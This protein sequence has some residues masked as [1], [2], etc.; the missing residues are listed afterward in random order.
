MSG[1]DAAVSSSPP[2]AVMV[3]SLDIHPLLDG[4]MPLPPTVLYPDVPETVWSAMSADLTADG[5]L[6]VPYGGFLV[7]DSERNRVLIDT[8]AGPNPSISPDGAL[9]QQYAELP[10]ALRSVG[11]APHQIDHVVLTHFH[12]DHVGWATLDG[13]PYFTRA[14]YH[15]HEL[16]WASLDPGHDARETLQPIS[17]QV[18]IWSGAQAQPLPWLTLHHVPGHSPGNTLVMIRDADDRNQLAVVG[19]LFHHPAGL[20]HPEW[21]CGF[22]ADAEVAA[23]QRTE[24]AARLRAAEIPVVSS[25]FPGLA[26][27]NAY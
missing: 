2:A 6:K 25:H 23:R 27:V 22:D 15:V 9:P 24:W 16:E 26:P 18:N 7:V 21:R 10:R 12:P 20:A 4:V 3:G 19:D 14:T 11:V 13:A 17:K 1:N 5:L 8:G